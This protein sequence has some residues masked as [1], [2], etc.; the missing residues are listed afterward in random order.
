M[1]IN[2]ETISDASRAIAFA[3]DVQG[4]YG[5]TAQMKEKIERYIA[6]VAA[7]QAETADA[8]ETKFVQL[9]QAIVDPADL[10]RNG[11]LLPL[12]A[13]LVAELEANYQDFINPQ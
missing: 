13:P 7:I 12:I 11:A 9:V 6:G 3:S 8:R 4:L 10:T 2:Q 5:L 1:A